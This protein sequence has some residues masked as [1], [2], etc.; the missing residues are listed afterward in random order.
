MKTRSS[1]D[2]EGLL[3]L[4]PVV[5]L[6]LFSLAD[7]D[8]HGYGIKKRVEEVSEGTVRLDAGTLYRWMARLLKDGLVIE[9]PRPRSKDEDER[10]RY[11]SLSRLGRRAVESESKRLASLL[12]GARQ[13]NLIGEEGG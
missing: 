1:N 2:I 6:I 5:Y 7:Q 3:P 8:R 11:Y 12:E 4:K 10:R 9:S 13:L